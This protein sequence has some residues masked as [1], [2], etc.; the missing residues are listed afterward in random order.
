MDST[1][2]TK[3]NKYDQNEVW[4]VSKQKITSKWQVSRCQQNQ[5][6]MNIGV[7]TTIFKHTSG[8]QQQLRMVA[9]HTIIL[10]RDMLLKT[11]KKK[12][13]H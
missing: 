2:V 10:D 6:S 11:L 9:L 8:Y 13:K 12:L 3:N 7:I 5:I 4:E 1:Y